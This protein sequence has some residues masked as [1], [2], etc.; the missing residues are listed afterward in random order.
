MSKTEAT[1]KVSLA[2]YDDMREE[3]KRLRKQTHEQNA[4]LDA[5]RMALG[6]HEEPKSTSNWT[7]IKLSDVPIPRGFHPYR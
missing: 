4:Q 5:V 7:T 2:E 6:P 1:V 3:L